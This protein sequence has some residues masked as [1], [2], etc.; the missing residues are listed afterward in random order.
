[1]GHP[2]FFASEWKRVSIQSQLSGAFY[3]FAI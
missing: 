2:L 1:M 3:I